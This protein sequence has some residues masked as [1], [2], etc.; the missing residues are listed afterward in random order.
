MAK[1]GKAMT[2]LKYWTC[3]NPSCD[4]KV[5]T[6]N[7]NDHK[8]VTILS[9]SLLTTVL[10]CGPG[11]GRDSPQ[12]FGDFDRRRNVGFPNLSKVGEIVKG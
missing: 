7:L 8:G 4:K 6:W 2:Q 1:K 3:P 11:C 5:G 10:P 9:A 12:Q